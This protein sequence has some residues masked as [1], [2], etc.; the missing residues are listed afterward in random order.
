MD[1]LKAIDRVAEILNSSDIKELRIKDGG[2]SIFMTQNNTAAITRVVS[3][4]P[5]ASNV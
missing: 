3:A 4:A 1:L 5:D 2:S